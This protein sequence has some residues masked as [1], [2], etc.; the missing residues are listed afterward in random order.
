MSK[1]AG[2]NMVSQAQLITQLTNIYEMNIFKYNLNLVVVLVSFCLIVL[3]HDCFISLFINYF[4][5][6]WEMILQMNSE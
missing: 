1:E 3:D 2:K 5:F 4:L 6:V